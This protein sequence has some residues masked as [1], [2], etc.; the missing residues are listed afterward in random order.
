M[1]REVEKRYVQAVGLVS[2][3][4]LSLF[5]I[6]FA[7]TGSLRYWFIPENLAL[8]WA[9]LFCAW[10]LVRQLSVSNWINWRSLILTLLWLIFLPNAWYVLTDF[11]HVRDTGEINQLFDIV[12]MSSLV[13]SGFTLGFTSLYLVHNE[14]RKRLSGW[15]TGTV[16][17]AVL[18]L[19]S[20]AIYLGRA[21]RW[22]SWDIVA[23]PSSLL[24]NVSDR[25]I[26]PFGHQRALNIT[27][28][29]FILLATLY[30]AIW[31]FMQPASY[32]SRR[33]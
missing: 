30:L 21:L 2:V 7:M 14:L 10:L 11:I 4:C 24:L 13:F 15:W 33:K 17:T 32:Q 31:L 28:L 27:G 6:R 9:S 20:F 23:N 25:V 18:L 26:D 19:S 22:N 29:F 5:V 12:M 8:A 16:V 1:H 3:L